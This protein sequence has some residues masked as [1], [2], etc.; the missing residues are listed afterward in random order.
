M[1]SIIWKYPLRIDDVQTLK[2]PVDA[3]PLAVKVQYG[4][5]HI[6]VRCSP[7][8]PQTEQDIRIYGTGNPIPDEANQSEEYVDTILH[9]GFVW[10]V[11]WVVP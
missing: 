10:H 9:E 2:V 5:P 7:G 1:T 11:Y 4:V 8:L 3:V 6:W